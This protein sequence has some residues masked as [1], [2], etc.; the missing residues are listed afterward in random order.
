MREIDP[1]RIINCYYRPGSLVHHILVEHSKRVTELALQLA[2][3]CPHLEIDR[4]FVYQAAM[5][6]DIGIIYTDAPGIA[7]Y[8]REPYIR[9]GYLGARLLREDWGLEA[10]ARVCERHTGSG[11]SDAERLALR[12]PIPSNR[13]YLP[14]TIEEQL[15]CYADSFYSKTHLGTRKKYETVR[16]KM[17]SFWQLR[18]PHLGV[19]ALARLDGMLQLFGDPDDI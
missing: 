1:F 12:L 16:Q 10:H 9:H 7:C 6:H 18:A 13:S 17:E 19:E 14:E 3:H 4:N 11:V 5:L 15:I 8:G 2:L